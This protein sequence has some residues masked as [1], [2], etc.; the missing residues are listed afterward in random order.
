MTKLYR[1]DSQ[2]AFMSGPMRREMALSA[3]MASRLSADSEARTAWWCPYRLRCPSCGEHEQ[4]GQECE[5]HSVRL[6]RRDQD[7]STSKIWQRGYARIIR[8]FLIF[9]Y[10][11]GAL[12]G[13]AMRPQVADVSLKRACLRSA[14]TATLVLGQFL[15]A[16]T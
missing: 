15:L 8:T 7:S 9:L 5:C 13:E 10:G 6:S 4:L 1:S 12:V 3:E 11:T 14:L 2:T 16:L